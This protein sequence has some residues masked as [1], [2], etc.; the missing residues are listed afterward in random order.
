M[1]WSLDGP[2]GLYVMV[3]SD[4]WYSAEMQA[5]SLGLVVLGFRVRDKVRY[6][7]VLWIVLVLGLAM[8]LELAH[9]TFLLHQ[10]PAE[11]RIPA[12]LHITHNHYLRCCPW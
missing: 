9:F 7:S 12:R 6:G 4:K 11:S 8:V 10:Q 2:F 3:M 1:G 5:C